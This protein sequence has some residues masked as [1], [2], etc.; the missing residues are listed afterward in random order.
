MKVFRLSH[1]DGEHTA[2]IV[3]TF[4]K[5]LDTTDPA[6][7]NKS[8]PIRAEIE[9]DVPTES[10]LREN[11][12]FCGGDEDED[13][14]IDFRDEADEFLNEVLCQLPS[15][16]APLSLGVHRGYETYSDTVSFDSLDEAKAAI[17]KLDEDQ[18]EVEEPTATTKLPID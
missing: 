17:A 1:D 16:F 14:E 2:K 13:E 8:N 18:D 4:E 12:D 11:S 9:F 15:T 10:Y 5:D 7:V 6:S 3:F